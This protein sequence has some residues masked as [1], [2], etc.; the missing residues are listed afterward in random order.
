MEGRDDG[1]P[2]RLGDFGEH[3]ADAEGRMHVDEVD[4]HLHDAL[5]ERLV[6]GRKPEVH[7]FGKRNVKSLV[8]DDGI[9]ILIDVIL[10]LGP[11]RRGLDVVRIGEQEVAHAVDHAVHHGQIDV[12]RDEDPELFAALRTRHGRGFEDADRLFPHLA[13]ASKISLS[14]ARHRR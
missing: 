8:A 13:H 7:E 10:R 3:L 1:D 14:R 4:I 9:G 6:P 12:H 11:H 2:L 5:L